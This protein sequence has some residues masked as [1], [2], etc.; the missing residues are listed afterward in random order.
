MK[1]PVAD[2]KTPQHITRLFPQVSIA[3]DLQDT[4]EQEQ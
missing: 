3:P 4:H 2:S 1:P